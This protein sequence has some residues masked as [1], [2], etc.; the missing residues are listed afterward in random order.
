MSE[1]RVKFVVRAASKKERMTTFCREFGISRTTGYRWRRRCEQAGSLIAVMEHSRHPKQSPAQTA[2]QREQ[3]RYVG[4][5]RCTRRE[6]P[7][8]AEHFVRALS[9]RGSL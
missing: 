8:L 6:I 7:R 1:Q 2:A 5:E 3:P 4:G 9:G